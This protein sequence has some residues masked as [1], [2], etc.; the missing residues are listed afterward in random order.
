MRRR[1]WIVAF[2]LMAILATLVV[3]SPASA[4]PNGVQF[5]PLRT[6]PNVFPG[7]TTS[8][9]LTITNYTKDNQTVLFSTETFKTIDTS[10]NYAFGNEEAAGWVQFSDQSLNLKPNEA[11]VENYRIAVPANAAPG[12]RYIALINT[13]IPEGA[14]P[15]ELHRVAT[16]VYLQV[17]GDVTQTGRM[18]SFDVP[19]ITSRTAFDVVTKLANSGNTHFRARVSLAVSRWPAKQGSSQTVAE[20][21]LLPGTVRQL[22]SKLYTPKLPGL[23]RVTA[24]FA[25]PQGGIERRQE[26]LVYIPWWSLVVVLILSFIIYHYTVKRRAV[27]AHK[28]QSASKNQPTKDS[29]KK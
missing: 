2:S 25:P 29:S 4:K 14:Q 15:T 7:T 24:T 8:G 26:L 23:Y 9:S 16:L 18:V 20:G 11:K 28:Q 19:N 10:Y 3:A 12:G 21:Y 22:T 27:A 13:V 1:G 5:S 17:N 6:Y